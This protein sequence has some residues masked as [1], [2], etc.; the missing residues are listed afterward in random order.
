[1]YFTDKQTTCS[2]TASMRTELTGSNRCTAGVL[3]ATGAAPVLE[4]CRLLLEAGRDPATALEVYRGPTLCLLVRAI[5]EAAQL[6]ING[7]GNGFSR[8]QAVGTAPLI[9]PFAFRHIGE[10]L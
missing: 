3:I 4:L 7:K 2:N 8:R 1:M 5:G 6:E 10:R 9:A